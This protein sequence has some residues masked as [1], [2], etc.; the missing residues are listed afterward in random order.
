LKCKILAPISSILKENV[1]IITPLCLALRSIRPDSLHSL[2]IF[3]LMEGKSPNVSQTRALTNLIAKIAPNILI[4]T[5]NF[6][7]S[8]NEDGPCVNIVE[9]FETCCICDESMKCYDCILKCDFCEDCYC[10]IDCSEGCF[11]WCECGTT[12][13][14]LL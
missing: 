14:G 5:P 1:S 2:A 3:E 6:C 7:E 8:Y 10:A 4:V 12:G 13:W 9:F 11:L